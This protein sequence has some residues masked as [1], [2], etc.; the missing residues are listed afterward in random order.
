[1][2]YIQNFVEYLLS[3][4]DAYAIW[5]DNREICELT[6][7]L[8]SPFTHIPLILNLKPCYS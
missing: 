5:L 6:L 4:V 7:P 3:K 1:M 2:P 8:G